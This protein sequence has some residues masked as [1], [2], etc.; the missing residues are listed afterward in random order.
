MSYT[1][2]NITNDPDHR[3]YEKLIELLTSEYKATFVSRIDGLN[4]SYCDFLVE[5]E[6]ITLHLQA[7]LGI[8]IFPFDL[9]CASSKA[10]YLAEIIG[11]KLKSQIS[12]LLN[13][14]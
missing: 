13:N 9:S 10:N 5:D 8:L 6:C 11:Q 4:E 2:V 7:Y 14:P 1:E 12:F 3:I